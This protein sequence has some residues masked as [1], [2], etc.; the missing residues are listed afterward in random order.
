M[1]SSAKWLLSFIVAVLCLT[2]VSLAMG[3]KSSAQAQG[4]PTGSYTLVIISDGGGGT[5]VPG[6]TQE[7]F[8]EDSRRQ[9]LNGHAGSFMDP[10]HRLL[11]IRSAYC[12]MV[13]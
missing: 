5:T 4:I 10:D 3:A 12:V 2:I 13:R 7:R 11:G 8:C 9:L 6:Y 1:S